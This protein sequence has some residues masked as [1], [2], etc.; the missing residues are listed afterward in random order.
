MP[1]NW[2]SSGVRGG[3]PGAAEAVTALEGDYNGNG[4]VEQADLDLVLLYWGQAAANAPPAWTNSRPSGVV[5][6]AEL[7]AV[8]L[9]WGATSDDVAAARVDPVAPAP[10][11]SVEQSD[12][13]GNDVRTEHHAKARDS[14]TIDDSGTSKASKGLLTLTSSRADSAKALVFTKLGM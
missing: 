10:L 9:N 12:G 11:E 7:D 13:L 5:D 6:Q 14:L 1:A 8:L 4:T 2:A 3:T